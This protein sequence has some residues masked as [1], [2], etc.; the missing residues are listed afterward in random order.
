MLSPPH[1]SLKTPGTFLLKPVNI[2]D[3]WFCGKFDV[4]NFSRTSPEMS[5]K[6]YSVSI[7]YI[8]E[9]VSVISNFAFDPYFFLM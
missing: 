5:L 9:P 7:S 6:K 1:S 4:W 8:K 2:P 3:G